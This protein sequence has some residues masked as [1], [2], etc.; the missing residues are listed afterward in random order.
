M[1][2][3]SGLCAAFVPASSALPIGMGGSV[4]QGYN[5]VFFAEEGPARG[6]KMQ[7]WISLLW[8]LRPQQAPVADAELS[9]P[10]TS[11][12]FVHVLRMAKDVDLR[13]QDFWHDAGS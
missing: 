7:D 11:A 5:N 1:H 8:D 3:P 4:V 9:C 10:P 13:V 2:S 12:H 6:P